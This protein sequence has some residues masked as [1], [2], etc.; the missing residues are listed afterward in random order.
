MIEKEL[1]IP[2]RIL[3]LEAMKDRIRDTH[4]KACDIQQELIW[5]WTGF[6]GER[7]V[8]YYLDFLPDKDYYIF[9]SLR[10]PSGKHFFQMDYLLLTARC[11]II[12]ECKNFYGTLSFDESFNQLIRIANDKE[13]G[14]QDPISQVKWHRQ[15]LL[16]FLRSLQIS[17]PVE[18]L[19]VISNP[20]TIIKTTPQNKLAL[21]KVVH[22]HSLLERIEE[23]VGRYQKESVDLKGIRRLSKLLLKHHTQ[24]TFD[25]I[26]KYGIKK[27]DIV[28]GV[29]CPECQRIPMIRKKGTWFCSSCGCKDKNAHVSALNDYFLIEG[30]SITNQK[31]RDFVHLESKDTAKRLFG[32]LNLPFTGTNKG[33]IY[34]KPENWDG[35]K[36][37]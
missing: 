12:L 8:S 3:S 25:V 35:S 15:Q 19:V 1:S 17:L 5:R 24:E 27:E 13:E 14:F 37:V 28:T 10:L 16:N 21:K 23:I 18:Y 4:P 9:H 20:S 32:A 26:K 33:R 11:I 2:I 7:A 22:G 29:K 36:K 30:P 34:H 6:K 31:F